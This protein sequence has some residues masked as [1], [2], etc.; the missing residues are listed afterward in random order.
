MPSNSK[1]SWKV[2]RR[3]PVPWTRWRCVA[4]VGWLVVTFKGGM[5]LGM[6]A[7]IRVYIKGVKGRIRVREWLIIVSNGLYITCILKGKTICSLYKPRVWWNDWI[8]GQLW[9]AGPCMG[10]NQVTSLKTVG[11]FSFGEYQAGAQP[12]NNHPSQLG[13]HPFLR[14][15]IH[16]RAH[17]GMYTMLWTWWFPG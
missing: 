8:P 4:L 13:N 1:P 17:L 10:H 6:I 11:W 9:L 12:S 3:T 5:I 2:E 14:H 16:E 7:V 15:T